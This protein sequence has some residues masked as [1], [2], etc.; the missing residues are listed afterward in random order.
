MSTPACE[1]ADTISRRIAELREAALPRC[2]LMPEKPL[3]D[4]LRTSTRC[5]EKC[6]HHADWLGPEAA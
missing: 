3:Y 5:G 6:P 2:P 4:C 1:D